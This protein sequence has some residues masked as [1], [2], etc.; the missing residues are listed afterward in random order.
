MQGQEMQSTDDRTVTG[1]TTTS[2]E[3]AE[4]IEEAI[5]QV[6]AQGLTGDAARHAVVEQVMERIDDPAQHALVAG[7]VHSRMDLG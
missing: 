2:M 3:M 7:H 5:A 1:A 4:L 6:T